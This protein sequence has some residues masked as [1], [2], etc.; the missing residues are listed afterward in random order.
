MSDKK[1]KRPRDLNS[2]E[3]KELLTQV[4]KFADQLIELFLEFFRRIANL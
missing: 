4:I 1:I 3:R 2:K